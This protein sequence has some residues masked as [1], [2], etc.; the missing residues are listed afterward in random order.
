MRT[1][2]SRT[3]SSEAQDDDEIVTTIT[4]VPLL[5][6]TFINY[7]REVSDFVFNPM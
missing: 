3:V 5:P 6:Q 2:S 1:R 7:R 4:A